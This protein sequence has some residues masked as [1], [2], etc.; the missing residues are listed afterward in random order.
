VARPRAVLLD[1]PLANVDVDLRR[2]LLAL[3]RE[4]LR[5]TGATAIHVTHDLREATGIAHR[6]AVIERGRI[7]QQGSL[8]HLRQSPATPFVES[9]VEDLDGPVSETSGARGAPARRSS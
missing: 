6:F 9:L 3:F 7:V 1:E 4:L 5:D 2:D 8:A